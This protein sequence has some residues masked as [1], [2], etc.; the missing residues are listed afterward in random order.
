MA[1]ATVKPDSA[2]SGHEKK[3]INSITTISSV[4]IAVG[5]ILNW[6]FG[7][8]STFPHWFFYLLS[9]LVAVILYKYFE[10]SIRR[11]IQV[12]SVRNYLR[13]T[14]FHLLDYLQRFSELV[15]Q[16]SEDSIVR[17]LE[18]VGTRIGQE[19][20]D[21]DIFAYSD[22]LISGLYLRMSESGKEMS[23]GE[24]K[25]ILND[26]SILIKFST[27]FYFKKPLL[28]GDLNRLTLEEK[29]E[30]ELARENFAD[31]VRRFQVFFDEVNAKIGSTARAHFEIP[32]PIS[33]GG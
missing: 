16:R 22:Q 5:T 31:Y 12:L 28:S 10:E 21:K 8:Q 23:L 25:G 9:I 17:V 24:V 29:K 20:V 30:L 1:E 32:K 27:L 18:G 19:M 2:S 13:Q 14:H 26:M 15:T 11:G 7:R 3:W 6:F 33:Y 4:L